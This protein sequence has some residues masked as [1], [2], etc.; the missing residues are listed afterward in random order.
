[1]S[2]KS[3]KVS[4]IILASHD[5]HYLL[6]TI[7]SVQKQTFA[8]LEISI[9]HSGESP[10]LVE[11]FEAQTDRRLK[12]S[13]EADLNPIHVLNL[14]IQEAKGE[15]IAF[16]QADDLW[17]PN[18]LQKQV[19]LLERYPTVGLIHSW[20]NVI[21]EARKPIGKTI[22]NQLY[23]AI[24]S[25]I[26]ERNQIGFSST[27]VRQP[28]FYMVGLF[29]PN[30][31]IN[32]DW[33]MWI[34]LS[35]CYQFMTMAEPLV[36]QRKRAERDRDSWL[37]AEKEYQLIIEKIYQ[38][39]PEKL[40]PLK[41]RSYGYASIDL[42][43]Q[44]LQHKDADPAIA[45]H[46]CRQALEHCP[47]VSFSREF[48]Q[49]SI[50]VASLYWSKSD[51]YLKLLATLRAIGKWLQVKTKKYRVSARF[52]LS[53]ILQEQLNK[54]KEDNRLRKKHEFFVRSNGE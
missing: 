13:I 30:L 3:P 41:A 27:I 8:D 53:W 9:C 37:D 4:V 24:E 38:N 42:A 16:L 5:N 52:L 54:E 28:C 21:S 19:F 51:R 2:I 23:G 17:H 40:L 25:E 33:D 48:L 10:Y 1:M 35:R 31:Q 49:L 44:V 47:R 26:L 18:K 6:E 15:Y 12:L 11:W 43:W 20:L 36:S 34:R 7:D 32:F 29:N 45:Y 46:Y 39:V 50:A 14:G 22:K